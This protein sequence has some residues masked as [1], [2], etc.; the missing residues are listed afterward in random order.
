M[1][2]PRDN[3][4]DRDEHIQE[5][6]PI[7]RPPRPAED[8]DD[9]DDEADRPRRRRPPPPP[10]VSRDDDAVSTIIPYRNAMALTAYYCAVFSLIPVFGLLLGPLALG[11][12]IAGLRRVRQDPEAKGTAHAITGIVLGSLTTLANWGVAALIFVASRR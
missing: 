9:F 1:V 4:M 10:R 3:D 7:K 11:F 2:S 12:G 8:L 6:K 5:A